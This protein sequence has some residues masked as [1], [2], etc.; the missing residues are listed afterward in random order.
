MKGGELKI[1]LNI[2]IILNFEKVY[3]KGNLICII[4][5]F[6]LIYCLEIKKV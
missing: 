5:I 3:L 2:I 6:I 1:F 4:D